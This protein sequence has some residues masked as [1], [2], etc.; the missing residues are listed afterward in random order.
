MRP[1]VDASKLGQE[2]DRS[3]PTRSRPS[4]DS[5][6][7]PRWSETSCAIALASDS[8][9]VVG[10]VKVT[11]R[12]LSAGSVGNSVETFDRDGT[13]SD[14]GTCAR[15]GC[16]KLPPSNPGTIR[17]RRL[18]GDTWGDSARWVVGIKTRRTKRTRP[19]PRIRRMEVK[20]SRG[21]RL[22]SALPRRGDPTEISGLSNVN[23]RR[24]VP[25]T[26]RTQRMNRGIILWPRLVNRSFSR[27]N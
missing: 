19:H 20:A 6:T 17:V 22:L 24:A 5:R 11:P 15:R 26:L 23:Q 7:A 9:R 3:G 16:V 14:A 8:D 25:P 12:S 13:Q 27:A 10:C 2:F 1:E 18:G 21:R 4:F